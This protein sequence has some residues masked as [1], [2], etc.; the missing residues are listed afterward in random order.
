ME[1]DETLIHQAQN[2]NDTAFDTILTR[3]KPLVKVK[4]KDYYLL[5]G[6]LEDL[7]QEG[8]IGLYKA[9]RDYSNSHN[10]SFATFASLCVVRQIQTAIKAANRQKHMPLNSSLTLENDVAGQ[11]SPETLVLGQ[12]AFRDI[13]DFIRNKLTGLE[14]SVL[15][16]HMDGKTHQQIGEELGKTKKSVDNT[17]QRIRKKIAA[18]RQ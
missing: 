2:G 9:V 5:G 11:S 3:Y 8:M 12:E 10:A 16:L 15:M 1:N 17:I 14:N 7:I 4:A 13:S 18:I 6:D